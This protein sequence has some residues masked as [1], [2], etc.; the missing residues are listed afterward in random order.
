MGLY[1]SARIG[2]F[3]TFEPVAVEQTKESRGCSNEVCEN[4]RSK[5]RKPLHYG[6]DKKFCELCGSAIKDFSVTT[7]FSTDKALDI[8]RYAQKRLDAKTADKL[9]DVLFVPENAESNFAVCNVSWDH[10]VKAPSFMKNNLAEET[11]AINLSQIKE[12]ELP[13]K[14]KAEI[15]WALDCVNTFFGSEVLKLNFGVYSYS[16]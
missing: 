6:K 4:H 2:F 14:M 12:P 3:F 15:E 8:V 1:V 13:P 10:G 7:T 9:G 5:N 11:S 16:H